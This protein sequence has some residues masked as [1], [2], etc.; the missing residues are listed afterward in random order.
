MSPLSS[1]FPVRLQFVSDWHVGTGEGRVGVVD[2]L[3]RR[4][5]DGLPFVPAKTLLGVWRDACETVARTLDGGDHGL[6]SAWVDWLFGSQPS[7]PD[8]ATAGRQHAPARAAL[9]LTPARLA[10][11]LRDAVRGKDPL[12]EA[13]VL[14]RPGVALHPE[15]GTAREDMLRLEERALGGLVLHGTAA[16]RGAEGGLPRPAELLLRAGARLVDA[17]GGKRNRGTGRVL[18]HLGDAPHPL[19]SLDPR[20]SAPAD[21]D[22]ATLLADDALLDNPG[23][24]EKQREHDD[25]PLLRDGRLS[26][27]RRRW[28]LELEALT[29][30]V[31]VDRVVGNNIRTRS[32]I[33]GTVL[34]P[35]VLAALADAHAVGLDDVRVGDA[36]PAV[37]DGDGVA[38]PA[39]REP[40]VWHRGDK[41]EG[42]DVLN[43]AL[44]ALEPRDRAKPCRQRVARLHRVGEPP[45]WQE[46]S[47]GTHVSTHAVVNDA[48]RRPTTEA[49]GGLFSYHGIE[50][51]TVLVSDLVLPDGVRLTLREG[52]TLRLGRS[53]KDDYGRVWV[54]RLA[55]LDD[56]AP[57]QV[58]ADGLLP[59]WLVSDVL[60]RDERLAFDPSPAR[61]ATVLGAALDVSLEPV[62]DD[63]RLRT[64]LTQPVRRDGFA[65]RWG[66]PRRS[67][68]GLRA[69]SVVTFRILGAPPDPVRVAGVERDGIGERTVEGFGRVVLDPPELRTAGPE[70]ARQ[71][72]RE[73]TPSA[74]G[75]SALQDVDASAAHPI[76]LAAWRRE[77]RR[78]VAEIAANPERQRTALPG[79]VAA[80]RSQRGVLRTQVA[81]LALPR[82]A[83]LVQDWLDSLDISVTRRGAWAPATL[84]QLKK[85]LLREGIWEALELHG[86]RPTLVLAG[87]REALLRQALH[88]EALTVLI[89]ELVRQ[90]HAD[91]EDRD[92]REVRA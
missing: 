14:L 56:E 17:L 75:G 23:Q 6:W 44:V 70:V 84:E 26:G 13:M 36:V 33:P 10:E 16:V 19:S 66:R 69:G 31:I 78:R 39:L 62:A 24:P 28:R 20:D 77:I 4:D 30:V 53:R 90:S 45:R 64:T 32:E 52:A 41:G 34:L 86:D 76:E 47:P 73:D 72:A 55:M 68:V 91:E 8:D 54:R 49:G 15:T 25:A 37:V 57:R 7:Q 2:A 89:E 58:G 46:R 48:E 21:G 40:A 5:G 29:P 27:S 22:L 83:E 1:T 12:V 87:G 3:V 9:S 42:R 82:G 92:G 88:R 38:H 65:P 71:P 61:L 59:V 35:A 11:G 79:L 81:R 51:G 43:A 50:P 80:S 63:P 74:T 67:L 18:L 85:L 60:L